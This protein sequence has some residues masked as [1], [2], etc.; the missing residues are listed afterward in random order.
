M[1][2]CAWAPVHKRRVLSLILPPCQAV[3]GPHSSL[4][5]CAQVH[6]YLPEADHPSKGTVR[7]VVEDSQDAYLGN[8]THI[9][10][11]SGESRKI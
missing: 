7:A 4:P 2:S 10:L 1:A 8:Q 11:D 6:V 5:A 3:H 9:F